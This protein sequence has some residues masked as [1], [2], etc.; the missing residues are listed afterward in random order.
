VTDDELVAAW[1]AE[2]RRRGL[3]GGTIDQRRR[4]YGRLQAAGDEP[5]IMSV[6]DLNRWLDG[7]QPPT[8]RGGNAVRSPVSVAGVRISRSE[9]RAAP[10]RS[11]TGRTGQSHD[12]R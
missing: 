6:D 9:Q 1:Q 3:A 8:V 4:L 11:A 7:R 5:S 12:E 10:R 2:M